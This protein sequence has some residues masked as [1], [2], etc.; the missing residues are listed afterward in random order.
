MRIT[1]AICVTALV[2]LIW[3][4]HLCAQ[5]TGWY[6][7]PILQGSGT[8]AAAR[9][10]PAGT[11]LI[12]WPPVQ[13]ELNLSEEQ[14]DK[15]EQ[16]DADLKGK[17]AELKGLS[18]LSK[19]DFAVKH[20]DL[21]DEAARR[22]VKLLSKA[23]TKRLGEIQLQTSEPEV[24]FNRGIAKE[25]QITPEQGRRIKEVY[26]KTRPQQSKEYMKI[27]RERDRKRDYRKIMR[28]YNRACTLKVLSILAESQK[29]KYRQMSG[30]PFEDI[31]ETFMV[32]NGPPVSAPVDKEKRPSGGGK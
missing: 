8:D 10:E 11:S 4:S 3:P 30:T 23:Q 28:E 16:L 13:K 1:T 14:T 20:R 12:L 15:L 26:T 5:Y 21:L 18:K 9:G 6:A 25:L 31:P 17:L 2:G 29:T 27:V 24:F 22:A 32:Y 19:K 7:R